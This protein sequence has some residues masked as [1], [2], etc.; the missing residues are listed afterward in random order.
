MRTQ[1]SVNY[2]RISIVTPS[3]N[4]AKYLSETIESVLNQ[5]YTNLEYIIID[6]DST[7]GSLDIIRRYEK[8]LTYWCSEKDN[9]QS[10]AIMKGF[11]R[12]TGELLA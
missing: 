11:D 10:D 5:N 2:P 6:G 12:A 3:F 4:Q 8:Q 9:D 7:D 1:T